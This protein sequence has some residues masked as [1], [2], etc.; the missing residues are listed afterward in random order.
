MWNAVQVIFVLF[1]VGAM[2]SMMWFTLILK[3]S[4]ESMKKRV[5]S[6][7]LVL[8]NQNITLQGV[9]GRW[10]TFLHFSIA[11]L[12]ISHITSKL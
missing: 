4:L 9:G 11:T 7:K 1:T 8:I 6:C 5:T 3:T 10:G 12:K 2:I